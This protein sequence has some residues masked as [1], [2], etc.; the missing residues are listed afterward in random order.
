MSRFAIVNTENKVVNV[1]IWEGA[2]FLPPRNHL[3]VKCPTGYTNIGDTYDSD[4]N[5]FIKPIQ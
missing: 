1:I 4:T 2:E 3:V 5:T